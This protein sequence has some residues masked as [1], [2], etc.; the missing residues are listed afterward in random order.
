MRRRKFIALMGAAA[1]WPLAASAQ[2]IGQVARVVLWLGGLGPSDPETQRVAAAFRES[3]RGLGW[4]DG[5]NLRIDLRWIGAAFSAQEMSA[6]ATET[7]SL[8]PDVVVTTGAPILAALQSET[9]TIPL[10]FT[11]VTDPVS[12]GFVASLARPGGN[13]TGF[14][15]FEHS[16][17]GKSTALGRIMRPPF[18]TRANASSA[19]AMS[20][21]LLTGVGVTSTPMRGA[22]VPRAR[23]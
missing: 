18:G 21:T 1:A 4:V 15:I 22:I 10:V 14:T 20:T 9:K 5:R 3:M 8:S 2:Q 7:I 17:A 12:D 23:K 11:F 6:A 19:G 16:F 13:I